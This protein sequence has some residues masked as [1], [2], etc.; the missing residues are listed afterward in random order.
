FLGKIPLLGFFFKTKSDSTERTELLVMIT[1]TIVTGEKLTLRGESDFIQ[2]DAKNYE[3]YDQLFGEEKK[4][5]KLSEDI[6]T[7]QVILKD[8]I[9]PYREYRSD[10]KTIDN[11]NIFRLKE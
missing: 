6:G 10:E 8:K 5:L 2:R 9:K 7:S 11:N 4:I 3:E 1:P